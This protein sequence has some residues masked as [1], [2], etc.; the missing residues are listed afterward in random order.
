MSRGLRGVVFWAERWG[1]RSFVYPALS[2]FR[3]SGAERLLPARFP[4]GLKPQYPLFNAYL[5]MMSARSLPSRRAREI[6]LSN[7][8][9]LLLADDIAGRGRGL[10]NLPR[11]FFH[12]LKYPSLH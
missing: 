11:H 6:S 2:L 7:L 1:L 10:V 9:F 3:R 4:P 12:K 5:W 8:V